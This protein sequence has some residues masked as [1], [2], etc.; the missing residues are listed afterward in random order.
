MPAYLMDMAHPL[1]IPAD[2]PL[3][4]TVLVCKLPDGLLALDVIGY[5]LRLVPTDTAHKL[6][7]AR[8]AFI[9]LF[10]ASHTV[11]DHIIRPTEKAFFLPYQ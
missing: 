7:S 9:Q 4:Y 10:A 1:R 8:L 5:Y 3:V 2:S 6:P 11:P